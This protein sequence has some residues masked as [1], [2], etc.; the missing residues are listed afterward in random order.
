MPG[1]ERVPYSRK[2]PSFWQYTAACS[3]LPRRLKI[4]SSWHSSFN[5]GEGNLTDKF[6]VPLEVKSSSGTPY[7][8]DAKVRNESPLTKGVAELFQRHGGIVLSKAK[9]SNSITWV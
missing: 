4:F 1:A 6:E 9:E 5:R 2:L 8:T 7:S 3:Q